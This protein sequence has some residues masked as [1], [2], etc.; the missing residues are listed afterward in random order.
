MHSK[1]ILL[2]FCNILVAGTIVVS[3]CTRAGGLTLP[4]V[5][6]DSYSGIA[7]PSPAR[8]RRAGR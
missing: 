1:I 6:Y 4:G 3:G 5:T 8:T 2:I 7:V